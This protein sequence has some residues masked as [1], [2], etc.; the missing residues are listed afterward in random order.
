MAPVETPAV[1]MMILNEC[2]TMS[3][4]EDGKGDICCMLASHPFSA[5][6][7]VLYFS[8]C[9]VLVFFALFCCFGRLLVCLGRFVGRFWCFVGL[10]VLCEMCF[11]LRASR[12]GCF[13]NFARMSRFA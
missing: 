1:T 5:V 9:F 7:C 8:W 3:G 11:A 12:V 4:I 13:H 10:R 6:C 2:I